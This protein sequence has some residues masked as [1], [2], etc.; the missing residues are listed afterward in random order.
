[1]SWMIDHQITSLS[2]GFLYL[3]VLLL[4]LPGNRKIPSWNFSLI[5]SII[6]GLLSLELQIIAIVPIILLALAAY[7]YQTEKVSIL[8]RSIS[9]I[10]VFIISIGLMLHQFPG[11]NN[12]NVLDHIHISRD[13]I[14]FT[15]NLNFDKTIV[16]IFILGFGHGLIS[17]KAEWLVLFKQ[18][19]VKFL[20][21]ILIL[22]IL[23]LVLQFIKFDFKIPNCIFIWTITNLLFVCVAEE[24][25][26]RGFIQKNLA[27][28]MSKR[29]YGN[30]LAII[31]TAILFGAAH[32]PGGVRY[33]I[34]TTVAGAG[35]GYM[36]FTTKRIEASILT[37]FGLN[38]THFLFF[39]YP[40]LIS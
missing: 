40:A 6:L 16:G 8:I 29:K 33:V 7:Y 9:G 5:I 37:H 11:F 28:I 30:Y 21:V 39:T 4:W 10:F 31:I 36:Y 12:L 34:L 23:A 18:M 27:L 1:M 25:F 14:P 19:A 13:G 32:Y 26:F 20:I 2:Y 15:L 3:S 17:N 24:A 38:L 22:I 35:Y